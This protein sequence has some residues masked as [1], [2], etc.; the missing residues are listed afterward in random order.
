MSEFDRLL[1]ILAEQSSS[2]V[3]GADQSSRSSSVPT[4]VSSDEEYYEEVPCD[5]NKWD[6]LRTRKGLA[7][8]RCRVCSVLWKTPS[9]QLRTLR[10]DKFVRCCPTENCTKL[11]IFRYKLPAKSR[12]KLLQRKRDEGIYIGNLPNF[13]GCTLENDPN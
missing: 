2:S 7:T 12:G 13:D 11:H 3:T 9:K 8:L 10:C 6:N 5:H 4:L 1:I